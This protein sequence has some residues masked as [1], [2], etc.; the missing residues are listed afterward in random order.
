MAWPVRPMVTMSS[1]LPGSLV[2]HSRS[3]CQARQPR[4]FS[5]NAAA[6][7]AELAAMSSWDG[8]DQTALAEAPRLVERAQAEG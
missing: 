1:V 7:D 3:I 2:P 5:A 8:A 6:R 4:R